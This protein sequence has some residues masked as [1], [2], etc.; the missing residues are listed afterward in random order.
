MVVEHG[1]LLGLIKVVE[2]RGGSGGLGKVVRENLRVIDFSDRMDEI[3]CQPNDLDKLVRGLSGLRSIW[4]SSRHV[5]RYSGSIE[6]HVEFVREREERERLAELGDGKGCLS[7]TGSLDRMS[8]G[9]NH[10]AGNSDST[11]AAAELRRLTLRSPMTDGTRLLITPT[12]DIKSSLNS[13]SARNSPTWVVVDLSMLIWQHFLYVG[14]PYRDH[15][16][17]H[18]I[19]KLL[20]VAEKCGVD[21]VFGLRNIEFDP[22]PESLVVGSAG[23]G[24]GRGS[25]RWRGGGGA[26]FRGEMST[27]D[28]V[29]RLRQ[30]RGVGSGSGVEY[31]V[32]QRRKVFEDSYCVV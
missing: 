9:G 19:Q 1:D 18:K 23:V 16:R 7:T 15:W 20:D 2:G 17:P 4:L 12:L 5:Q 22:L 28:W 32:K 31:C 21:V 27:K 6:E 8:G 3:V 14:P 11:T 24:D 13:G 30:V 25:Q 10:S 29:L 26:V